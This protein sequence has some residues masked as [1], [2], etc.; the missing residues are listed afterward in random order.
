MTCTCTD[1]SA[2]HDA[3]T[4][5]CCQTNPLC[6]CAQC[7]ALRGEGYTPVEPAERGEDDWTK[8]IA[9]GDPYTMICCDCGLAHAIQF[10]VRDGRVVLRVKRDDETT[11]A[12]RHYGE[13]RCRAVEEVDDGSFE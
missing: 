2:R 7:E 12:E 10:R 1:K 11:A 4:C 13:F 9:P 6:R 3:A 5:D 8:W